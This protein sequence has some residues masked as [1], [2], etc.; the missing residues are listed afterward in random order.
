MKCLFCKIASGDLDADVVYENADVVA[1]R[2]LHPQARHHILI[3]PRRHIATLNDATEQDAGLLGK[4]LL[5]AR[6]LAGELGVAG[7]GYRLV[8]NCNRDG[9]QTVFHLHLHLLAGR[10]LHWPPV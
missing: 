6:Y 7:D 8:M 2:D 4:M 3:I 5:A 10:Q 1:F 9:G